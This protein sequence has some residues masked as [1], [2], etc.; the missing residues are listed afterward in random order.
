MLFVRW[1]ALICSV[2]VGFSLV[3]FYLYSSMP[4]PTRCL[5]LL[6]TSIWRPVPHGI[7]SHPTE[8]YASQLWLLQLL[9]E[10]I[11]SFLH[12]TSIQGYSKWTNK[13]GQKCAT[14][15]FTRRHEK[16]I[17]SR[18]LLWN[19]PILVFWLTQGVILQYQMEFNRLWLPYSSTVRES[20][21][22]GFKTSI[23]TRSWYMLYQK[24]KGDEILLKS[25][26]QKF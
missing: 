25:W 6:T 12:A 10:T 14:K 2:D 11:A 19:P 18:R 17:T 8:E 3:S 24:I 4:N 16:S 7:A 15:V 9:E 1:I 22:Q 5:I 26:R 20:S 23:A 13:N 21:T